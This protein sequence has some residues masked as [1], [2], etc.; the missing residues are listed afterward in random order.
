[1]SFTN[2]LIEAIAENFIDAMTEII[3]HAGEYGDTD[4]LEKIAAILRDNGYAV[5]D[6]EKYAAR[7][8]AAAKVVEFA[9]RAQPRLVESGW[10]GY[11]HNLEAAIKEW[12][13]A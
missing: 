12:E 3:E 2:K 4:T 11:A 13:Q 5:V 9:K 1:M 7:E 6:E 8:A 10:I